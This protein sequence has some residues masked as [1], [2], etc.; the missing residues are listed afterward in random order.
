[1]VYAAGVDPQIVRFEC[2]QRSASASA[3][4]SQSCAPGDA[5]NASS[6]SSW[7]DRPGAALGTPASSAMDV[8][9]A[10]VGVGGC[11]SVWLRGELLR[12]HTHDVKALVLLPD[13]LV[14]GGHSNDRRFFMR[15]TTGEWRA[16]KL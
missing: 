2:V 9:G 14:S 5:A 15:F 13:R 8:D 16:N 1:M 6:S 3:S 7:L 11:D 4:A 12:H 10:G